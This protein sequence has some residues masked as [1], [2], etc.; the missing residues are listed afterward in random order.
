MK[1][2]SATAGKPLRRYRTG[3]FPLGGM[4]PDR[5]RPW[6]GLLVLALVV[7]A[8]LVTLTLVEFGAGP[9]P[10]TALGRAWDRWD[11]QHYLYLATHGYAATGDARNLIAR[12]G[13][14]PQAVDDTIANLE[15]VMG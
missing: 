11:A 14:G 15:L 2:L 3:T 1:S 9:D 13:Q 12:L 7:K 8:V 5:I 4:V 6:M 10:L